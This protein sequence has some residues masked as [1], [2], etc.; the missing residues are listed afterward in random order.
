MPPTT[1]SFTTGDAYLPDVGQMS[2]NGCVFSPL[3]VSTVNGTAIKD[4]ANRTVKL[5]EYVLTVDG[6]VTLSHATL[7]AGNIAA[8]MAQLSTLLTQQGGSLVYRG[9]GFD[10]IV[11]PPGG[12][13]RTPDYDVAWGPVPEVLEFQP[14]GGGRSAKVVWRVTVRVVTGG[15]A[16][17]GGRLTGVVGPG[18][19]FIDLLQFNCETSVSYGEDYYSTL[20]VRG[21]MEIPLTRP[22]VDTRRVTFTVDDVRSELQRRIFDGID[23]SRFRVVNREFPISRDKRTMH[24]S[25]TAEEKPYMDLPEFCPVARGSFTVRPARSGMGLVLWLCTLRATY[26]V[27]AGFPRRMAWYP[28]LWLLRERMYASQDG[29]IG[30]IP[31]AQSQNPRDVR[32]ITLFGQTVAFNVPNR[33]NGAQEWRQALQQS[34]AN[35]PTRAWLIDFGIDEGLYLDSKTVSFSATWRLVTTFSHILVASGIWR[36]LPDNDAGGNNIWAASMKD[37]SGPFSIL[38]NVL[39]PARDVIVDFGGG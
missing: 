16:A 33:G 39:D 7:N 5:M 28:F 35:G 26:T 25:V 3:F 8:T 20:N 21:T 27:A 6:Y 31:D 18:P 34:R 22:A 32:Q 14:L 19:Q 2:Y 37:I 9:R 15:K 23:L 36:K 11:N 4:D 1:F 30:G 38:P 24:F 29:N 17:G 12:V 10:L 13:I